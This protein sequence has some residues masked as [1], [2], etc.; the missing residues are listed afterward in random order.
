MITIFLVIVAVL[1]GWFAASYN[2]FIKLINRAKEAWADIDVQLK[3]RYDLIPNLV[4]TVKGYAAHEKQAFEKVTEARSAAMS[5][6]NPAIKAQA[7]GELSGAL[8]RL[9]PWLKPIQNL[10]PIPISSTFSENFRILKIK[11][12]RLDDFTILMCATSILRLICFLQISLPRCFIF[13]KWNF[14]NLGSRCRRSKSG[15]GYI[16]KPWKSKT[17]KLHRV[18]IT[19][20]IYNH[21]GKYLITRRS[22]K[23]K[24]FPGMWTV[25]G[26]QMSVD[27]YIEYT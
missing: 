21:E 2:G 14:S 3:R 5:A 16:L 24:A 23:R 11:F 15:R 8:T 27:D 19:A 25:P 22:M 7:E 4:N 10:K 26:G 12:K 13:L 17:P 18:A 1:A 20:I 9:L 6:Q